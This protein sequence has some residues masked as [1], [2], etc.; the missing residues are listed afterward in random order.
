L[1]IPTFPHLWNRHHQLDGRAK[2][3]P[4]FHSLEQPTYLQSN[5]H[6]YERL[7]KTHIV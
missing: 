2:A 3:C 1:N 5:K 7:S 4:E 6:D